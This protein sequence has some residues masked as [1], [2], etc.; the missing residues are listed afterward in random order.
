MPRKKQ[1]SQALSFLD[2]ESGDS[3]PRLQLMSV[4]AI[5]PVNSKVSVQDHEETFN[6]SS[7]KKTTRCDVKLKKLDKDLL[8]KPQEYEREGT[9]D[10]AKVLNLFGSCSSLPHSLPS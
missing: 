7:S 2:E 1:R 3:S 10:Q 9:V 8:L 5:S 4:S 6:E